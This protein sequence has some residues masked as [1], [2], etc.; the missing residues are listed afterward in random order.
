MIEA[1]TS[2]LLSGG[3]KVNLCLVL[4]PLACRADQKDHFGLNRL[5]V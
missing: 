3:M 5:D 1:A 2:V 4:R